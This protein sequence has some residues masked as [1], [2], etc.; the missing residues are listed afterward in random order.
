MDGRERWRINSERSTLKFAIDHAGLKQICGRFHC[1]GGTVL[2]DNRDLTRSAVRI[3]V[4][5]SSIDTGSVKRDAFILATEL[6]DIHW[7]PALVF[8]SE[9]VEIT[10]IGRG[11]IFGRLALHS[12]GRE[13]A[14]EVEA[15]SPRA[16]SKGVWHLVYTARTS[17]DRG[18]LG[19][20]RNR[21]NDDWLSEAVVGEIIEITAH[22]EVMP[23]DRPIVDRPASPA[24]VSRM[25]RLGPAR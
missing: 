16:D 10:G 14:L 17:V 9:R 20:R 24:P 21:Y 1:W 7:E 25:Q 8:D 18:A 13:I 5:L 3:W 4:D 15:K 2:I 23:D 11:L 6:F 22:V 12:F 19:L